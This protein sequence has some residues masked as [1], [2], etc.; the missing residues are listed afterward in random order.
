M[1]TLSSFLA[2]LGL[3]IILSACGKQSKMSHLLVRMTDAPGDYDQ[4]NVEIIGVEIHYSGHDSA[5]WIALPTNQSIYD[6]LLLQNDITTVLTGSEQI[7]PGKVT[8]MRL[9]LGENNSVMVDSLMYP[10]K[11]PSAQQ[12]G[13][14]INLNHTFL[15]GKNYEILVDFDA[16]KSVVESDSGKYILKP[17]KS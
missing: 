10:L 17:V 8:Q 6:L 1:K 11:T 12:S 16:N 7:S 2:I 4:V 5:K 13:L 14:K 15:A 3:S 9:I